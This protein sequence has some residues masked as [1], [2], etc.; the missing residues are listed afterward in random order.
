MEDHP[1]WLTIYEVEDLIKNYDMELGMHSYYHDLVYVKGKTE[2]ERMW[3]MYKITKDIDKMKQL[4]KFYDVRSALSEEGYQVLNGYITKRNYDQFTEFIKSDTYL[5][6]KWFKKYFG[7]PELYAYPF[8][9]G[10]VELD[11]ELY[12]YGIKKDNIFGKRENVE[13]AKK[14]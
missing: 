11:N 3:R 8:F 14:K 2:P 6:V 12:K 9:Q 7:V 4:I 10:S 5:C 13:N 1:Q